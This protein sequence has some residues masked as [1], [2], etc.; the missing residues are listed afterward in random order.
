M[1][2]SGKTPQRQPANNHSTFSTRGNNTWEFAKDIFKI[3]DKLGAGQSE[4]EIAYFEAESTRDHGGLE[5]L[6][7][8]ARLLNAERGD[9]DIEKKI[10]V[11]GSG[12]VPGIYVDNP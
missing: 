12:V 8:A 7:L 1:K 5:N 4:T 10:V 9:A 6:R 2:A 3:G 11:T